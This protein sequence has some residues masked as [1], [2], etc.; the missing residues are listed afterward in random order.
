MYPKKTHW[1]SE[2]RPELHG[3]EV[4]LAGWVWDKRDIGRVKFLL[5]RDREGVVQITLKTGKTPQ[6][7]FE[8]FQELG[9]K[10]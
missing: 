1:T 4:V 3:A 8:I 2:I 5:L 9:E 7:L 6:H 10:T